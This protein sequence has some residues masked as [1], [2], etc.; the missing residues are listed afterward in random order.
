MSGDLES[1]KQEAADRALELVRPGMVVGLGTGSTARYFVEGLGRRVR[2]GLQIS[3]VATSRATAELAASLRIVTTEDVENIDL[4]V[5]GADEIDPALNLI[6]GRG[7]A[8]AREKLVASAAR[9]FV[10][11][12]DETKLVDQLGRSSLPVEVIPFLWRLTARRL[13]ALGAT[14][15]L[16]GDRAHPFVTDNGNLVL[17]LTFPGP[18][19]DPRGVGE[20]IKA[21]LG[22]VEH[23]VFAGLASACIVAGHDGVRVLGSLE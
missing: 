9:R 21:T 4:A 8:M 19:V 2:E 20:A 5:D 3:A 13:S 15:E 10:V 14:G 12:A 18:M 11:V 22:V 1:L 17:D 16:R 7:G 6:K 23:G